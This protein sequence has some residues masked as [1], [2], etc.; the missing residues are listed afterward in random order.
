VGAVNTVLGEIFPENMGLTDAHNH[1]WIDSIPCR[2]PNPPVLNQQQEILAELIEYARAGGKTIL[3][4]QP[5]GCGRNANQLA[6]L[7]RLSGVQIISSTGF[8]RPIYF[9]PDYWL[10]R[11]PTDAITRHF[12]AEARTGMLETVYQEIP[13]K[14]GFIKIA[15]EESLQKTYRPALDAAAA[16]ALETGLSIEIH[17]EKGA[18]AENI[19]DFFLKHGLRPGKIVI[20][21]IDKR[22]DIGLHRALAQAGLFLEYDTFYRPLYHPEKYL[23]NLIVEMVTAGHETQITLAT[24]MAQATMWTNLGGAPGLAYFPKHIRKRLHDMGFS[25]NCIDNLMGANISRCLA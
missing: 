8:H 25:D 17:T 4:C 5:A 6:A 13:I 18:D 24:D 15:C 21:H 9:V 1:V 11:A 2:A 10:W 22:P 19:A 3:D 12:V 16:A 7:S 14:A 20:C 23:W